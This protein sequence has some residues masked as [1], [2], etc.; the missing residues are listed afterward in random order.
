MRLVERRGRTQNQ[1]LITVS[2]FFEFTITQKLREREFETLRI[3]ELEALDF[4]DED[5]NFQSTTLIQ[6]PIFNSRSSPLKGFCFCFHGE[7]QTISIPYSQVLFFLY[8]R[9]YL[10]H[11]VH[12]RHSHSSR[13]WNPLDPWE[14]RRFN[15][16]SRSQL[17]CAQNFWWVC[18]LLGLAFNFLFGLGCFFFF[19]DYKGFVCLFV[20]LLFISAS[21]RRKAS[22]GL[23]WSHGNLELSF[24]TTFW[25][26]LLPDL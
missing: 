8:S 7:T 24:I 1:S 10:A 9:L 16:G 12:F 25:Y 13:P 21:T 5:Q 19:I 2:K 23:K 22:S 11:Y 20:F 26:S 6:I 18:D 3:R 17:D 14:F 4:G 15:Q